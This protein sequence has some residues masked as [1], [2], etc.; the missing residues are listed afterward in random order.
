[1]TF[2]VM[3]LQSTMALNITTFSKMIFSIMTHTNMAL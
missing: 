3:T 2:V 1:V